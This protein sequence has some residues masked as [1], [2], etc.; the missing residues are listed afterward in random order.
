MLTALI[1]PPTAGGVAGLGLAT[2][3][4]AGVALVGRIRQVS[5]PKPGKDQ[6]RTP[7]R[8]FTRSPPRKKSIPWVPTERPPLAR[9]WYTYWSPSGGP[10]GVDEVRYHSWA[11]LSSSRI[12]CRRARLSRAAALPATLGGFF[13]VN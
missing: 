8:P 13:S 9:G 7:V 4:V 1:A 10:A 11:L 12:T 5:A 6:C 3:N 2:V